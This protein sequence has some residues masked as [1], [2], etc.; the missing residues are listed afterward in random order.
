M[1][2]PQTVSGKDF[3]HCSVSFI[4]NFNGFIAASWKTSALGQAAEKETGWAKLDSL[5]NSADGEAVIGFGSLSCSS[6]ASVM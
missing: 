4:Q 6:H 1:R 3:C 5:D 2:L